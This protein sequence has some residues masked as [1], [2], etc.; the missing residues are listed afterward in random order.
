[1]VSVT[2]W[3][4]FIFDLFILIRF[5]SRFAAF[6][7]ELSAHF[8]ILPA[9]LN[10]K[11]FWFFAVAF[12]FRHW[13]FV[14]DLVFLLIFIW[15]LWSYCVVWFMFKN[16]RN[17]V[18]MFEFKLF[19]VVLFGCFFFSLASDSYFGSNSLCALTFRCSA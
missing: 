10:R 6:M 15:T 17:F 4:Y 19:A 16:K 1:M 2:I 9:A 14:R 13:D 18:G 3:P 12:I 5:I 11:R 7:L 8:S